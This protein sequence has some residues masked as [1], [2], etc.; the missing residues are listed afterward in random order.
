MEI[1]LFALCFRNRDKLRSGGPLGSYADLTL[2]FTLGKAV[3]VNPLS[4]DNSI[5]RTPLLDG[6]LVLVPAV[7]QSLYCNLTPYK[8]DTFLRRTR[9][10]L[11]SSTDTCEV[12]FLVK[13]TS[14]RIVAA[15]NDSKLQNNVSK[16]LTA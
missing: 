2:P 6:H 10:T 9:D 3:T 8:T 4:T 12:V 14:K 13:N 11:K 16:I 7:F 1:L 5:R 15:E